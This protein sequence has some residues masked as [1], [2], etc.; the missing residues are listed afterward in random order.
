MKIEAGKTYKG[1]SGMTVQV[2]KVTPEAVYY[3]QPEYPLS[4]NSTREVFERWA[5]EEVAK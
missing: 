5:I 4:Q 1:N 2:V 3:Y